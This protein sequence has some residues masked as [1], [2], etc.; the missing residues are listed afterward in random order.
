MFAIAADLNLDQI[1]QLRDQ[2]NWML[3]NH[4]QLRDEA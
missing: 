3:A 4:Y 2:L 1:E